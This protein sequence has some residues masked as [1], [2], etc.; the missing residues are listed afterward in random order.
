M[1]LNGITSESTNLYDP[2]FSIWKMYKILFNQWSLLF[3]I[4]FENNNLGVPKASLV[5]ISKAIFYF[6]GGNRKVNIRSD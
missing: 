5:E 6:Y 1:E 2:D 4:G 3:R